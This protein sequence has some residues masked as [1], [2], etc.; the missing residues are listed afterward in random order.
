MGQVDAHVEFFFCQFANNWAFSNGGALQLMNS[1]SGAF[2]ACT[3][4]NNTAS[5]G[6]VINLTDQAKPL[7][8]NCTFSNNTAFSMG[9]TATIRSFAFGRFDNCRFDNNASPTGKGGVLTV[10]D[11][12]FVVATQCHFRYCHPCILLLPLLLATASYQPI[13][14][15]GCVNTTSNNRATTGGVS[16]IS[17]KTESLFRACEFLANTADSVGGVAHLVTAVGVTFTD[18]VLKYVGRRCANSIIPCNHL[19]SY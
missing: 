11:R 18:S 3:F 2:H 9:G 15:P 5:E 16:H 10:L 17:S 6:G 14:C 13:H 19:V 8:S 4:T 1:F 7:F 12:A